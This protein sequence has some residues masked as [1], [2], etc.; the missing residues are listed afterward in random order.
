MQIWLGISIKNQNFCS[1][2][3]CPF[4]LSGLEFQFGG[5]QHLSLA[6]QKV[7]VINWKL[8]LF[9]EVEVRN[10][11]FELQT[12]NFKGFQFRSSKRF[13]R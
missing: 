12:V 4:A 7:A 5:L 11:S 1:L 13:D 2:I 6:Y 3:T 8:I 10:S 9:L